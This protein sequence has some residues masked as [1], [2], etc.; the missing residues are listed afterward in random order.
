MG[1]VMNWYEWNSQEEFDIWHNNLCES[2]GYP[3]ISVNQLS[4][5]IDN[6]VQKTVRYTTSRE[7]QGK[8]IA[9]VEEQYAEGLVLTE[10]R[11][12]VRNPEAY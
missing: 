7:V 8:I 3:L 1:A 4:G 10:L 12:P 5:E 11:P 6:K 9:D 2:L